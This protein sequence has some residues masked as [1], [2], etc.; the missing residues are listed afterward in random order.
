MTLK[1]KVRSR[2]PLNI[3]A[4]KNEALMVNFFFARGDFVSTV[5][6]DEET[7]LEYIKKLEKEDE[8]YDQLVF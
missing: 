4:K 8:P 1:A 5:G 7:I 3:V 2:L 6:L